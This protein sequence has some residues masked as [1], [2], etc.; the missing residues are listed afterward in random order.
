MGGMD[1]TVTPGDASA[2]TPVTIETSTPQSGVVIICWYAG[3]VTFGLRQC[4]C[5]APPETQPRLNMPVKLGTA[6]ELQCAGCTRRYRVTLTASQIAG[7]E[8][9]W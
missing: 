3:S 5:G 2:H 1:Q 7:P 9:S 4:P 6:I 8:T